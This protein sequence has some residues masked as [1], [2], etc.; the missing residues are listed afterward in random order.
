MQHQRY[1]EARRVLNDIA[2]IN[3]V[4]P[5]SHLSKL[6]EIQINY[7]PLTNKQKR[8]TFWHIFRTSKLTQYILALAFS[9]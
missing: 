3:G 2:Q 6:I 7:R 4:D 9:W 1:S 8:Y 5:P